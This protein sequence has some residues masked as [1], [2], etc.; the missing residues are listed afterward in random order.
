MEDSKNV[1]NIR[2][3]INIA[4]YSWFVCLFGSMAYQPLYDI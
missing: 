4:D 3:V 1:I 2:Q